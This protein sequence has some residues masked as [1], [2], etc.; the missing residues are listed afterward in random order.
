MRTFNSAIPGEA[1]RKRRVN[2]S[3]SVSVCQAD[4][5]APLA[6]TDK[7][8]VFWRSAFLTRLLGLFQAH[9]HQFSTVTT[10][11]ENSTAS[12]T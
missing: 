11:T 10:W 12:A 6:E 4:P 7:Q 8:V 5:K 2:A 3:R 9:V 1:G